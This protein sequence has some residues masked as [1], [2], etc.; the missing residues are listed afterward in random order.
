MGLLHWGI[1]MQTLLI[2][3]GSALL[4]QSFYGMPNKI[5]NTN[6]Q[7]VEAVVCF[8]G[9]LLK[10]LRALSPDRLLVVFDGENPLLRREI[11]PEYKANRTLPED[12][13]PFEQ[14]PFIQ[15]VLTHLGFAWKETTDSEADDFIARTVRQYKDEYRIVISSPDKDFY[16]LISDTVCVYTYRGKVSQLWTREAILE[17]YGFSAE[18]FSTLKALSGDASDNVKGIRGIGVKTAANL[19]ARF[20]DLNNIY[21]HLQDVSERTKKLLE[22]NKALAY[23][24]FSLVDLSTQT[25]PVDLPSLAYSLPDRSSTEI[26]KELHIL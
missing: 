11:D 25:A 14:L 21:A 23:K 10:T 24:N 15:S 19:I 4:F 9:I 8:T 6:G 17:K 18:Y 12:D 5:R 26:L 3:D 22:E 1:A 7:S 2:I 20:G 16:Q 13:S